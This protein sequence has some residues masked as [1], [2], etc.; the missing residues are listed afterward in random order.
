MPKFVP[1]LSHLVKAP[2]R[3]RFGKVGFLDLRANDCRY[4]TET[5]DRRG[6]YFFCGAPKDPASE[7]YCKEHQALCNSGVYVRKRVA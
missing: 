2:Q 3:E 5:L 4:P 6:E 7:S 1:D